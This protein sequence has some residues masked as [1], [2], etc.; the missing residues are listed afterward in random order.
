MHPVSFPHD[1]SMAISEYLSY[2]ILLPLCFL[3]PLS[4]LAAVKLSSTASASVPR[5]WVL[6]GMLPA[7]LRNAHRIHEFATD[8]VKA[9][10][11]TFELKGP[12][13]ANM[14]MLVTSDPANIHHILSRNFV[15]YPKGPQFRRIFDVLGDG[16]FNVD[17][18]LW[19][20]HRK[21]TIA[22][23]THSRFRSLLEKNVWG[24]VE[25]GLLP[26]LDSF[27]GSGA[28]FD[29]QDIFQRFTFDSIATLLLQEDPGSL[30]V[31]LPY[32]P[33]EKAFNRAVDALLYRHILPEPV[34]RAQN[35]L[36]VG[37]EKK[38]NHARRDIDD[39]IF[40]CIRIRREREEEQSRA[41][42]SGGL[43]STAAAGDGSLFSAFGKEYDDQFLRDTFFSLIFAGRDTTSTTL[44]WLFWL[45]DRNPAV[46]EK[47]RREIQEKL[48]NSPSPSPSRLKCFKVEDCQKLVYLHGALCE[49]LRLYPPVALEH[50]VSAADD[51][52]P[53]GHRVKPNTR[54]ILSIY[55]TGR[56]E[57]VWGEDCMEFRPERWISDRA[58]GGVKHE[59]SYKFPAFNAGP[60][61]CLGKEMAFV[62]MK[63]V[64][65][66]ILQHYNFRVVDPD[67][68]S[69]SDSIII[70]AKH[71]L[72]VQFSQRN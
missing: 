13:F 21:T 25:N 33:C 59:P 38:L 24:K 37:K 9:G 40:S 70:Q 54:V 60:R 4:Y 69:T 43:C 36:G 23:L 52:L 49:S 47:V 29:L 56:M 46:Q 63:M 50:K 57:S 64:A 14:D 55:S 65:A 10:G 19:E 51:V 18:H 3:L 41:N 5:D 53:S 42:N 31:D 12:V 30:T 7:L 2:A 72:K 17:S 22:F 20:L 11:G 35:W 6:V 39:F 16:I 45:L 32:V 71:G 66:T 44:T 8:L 61:T 15:N 67:S 27:A 26:V 34:W 1:T 28:H 48:Y 62:Q 58:G 68:V